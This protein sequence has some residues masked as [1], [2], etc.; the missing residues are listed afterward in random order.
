MAAEVSSLIN[1]HLNIITEDSTLKQALERLDKVRVK[2]LLVVADES[3]VAALTD[4]DVRRAILTGG[5]LETPIREIANY[6]PIY[7]E[8]D[9]KEAAMKYID[10]KEIAAVPVITP[11]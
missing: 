8:H 5:S 1:F 2:V 9:D 3:F 10:K 11:D 4:G 6:H 7:L